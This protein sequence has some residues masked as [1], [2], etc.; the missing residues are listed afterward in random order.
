[1]TGKKIYKMNR[2]FIDKNFTSEYNILKIN[3]YL[4]LR[5]W[6]R[7]CENQEYPGEQAALNRGKG[8]LA[9]V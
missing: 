9:E 6:G 5:G 7:G 3:I 2:I 1:M 4:T 8:V